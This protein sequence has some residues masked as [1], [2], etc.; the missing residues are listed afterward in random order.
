MLFF[1]FFE[2]DVVHMPSLS[3]SKVNLEKES[4]LIYLGSENKLKNF[5]AQHP[6][7]RQRNRRGAPVVRLKGV[8]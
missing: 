1:D 4:K 6:H 3:D 5:Q 2:L 8:L 7:L